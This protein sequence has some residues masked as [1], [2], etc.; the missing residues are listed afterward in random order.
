MVKKYRVNYSLLK[1][2]VTEKW[3]RVWVTVFVKLLK[4]LFSPV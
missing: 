3:G 2:P 1:T 4:F